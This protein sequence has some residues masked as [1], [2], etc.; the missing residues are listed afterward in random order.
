MAVFPIVGWGI[1]IV[2]HGLAA[3]ERP[4]TDEQIRREMQRIARGT[5]A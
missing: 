2:F 4:L 1:G 3:F 5:G